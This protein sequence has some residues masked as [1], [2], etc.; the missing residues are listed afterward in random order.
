MRPI[1]VFTVFLLL[2]SYCMAAD[3]AAVE[4]KALKLW[5]TE[6]VPPRRT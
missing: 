4:K 1:T 3:Q 6:R 2:G 5:E